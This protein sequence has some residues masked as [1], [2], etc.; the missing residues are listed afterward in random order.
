M[1]CAPLLIVAAAAC[2]NESGG[3][4]Q[5]KPEEETRKLA[6]VFPD[7]FICKS[8]A[9]EEQLAAVIGGTVKQIDTPSSVPRGV[10]KPCNYE[11]SGLALPEYW[12][13]DFDCR[14]NYQQTADALFAQYT[15]TSAELVEQY[16]AMT[17]A[18]PKEGALIKRDAGVKD[19]GIDAP[20]R[21]PEPS[22]EVAVGK[23]G[24][25]HHGQGL[26]FVDDDAPC[27]VR[28][29]GPEAARRLELA[30]L[31]AKNLT[32]ANAPMTPRPFK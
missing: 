15:R 19:A 21:A 17:D 10:A 29:V 3:S 12:T 11:V 22:A 13:F 2:S 16:N 6:G 1:R 28:V 31:I 4:N 7:R 30:K 24:L 23:K 18:G 9:S 26:L 25:D 32:Y 8:I 27:Y 14:D 20:Q 5:A